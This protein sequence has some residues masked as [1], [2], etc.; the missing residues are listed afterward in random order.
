MGL[1]ASPSKL[2]VCLLHLHFKTR[3]HPVTG[4]GVFGEVR[5]EAKARHVIFLPQNQDSNYTRE[6]SSQPY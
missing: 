5:T 6:L 2:M 3:K 1:A 4:Q